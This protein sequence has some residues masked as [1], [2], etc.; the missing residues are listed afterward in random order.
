MKKVFFFLF[1]QRILIK[2]STLTYISKFQLFFQFYFSNKNSFTCSFSSS[3]FKTRIEIV[4]CSFPL[5]ILNPKI[6]NCQ[7]GKQRFLYYFFYSIFVKRERERGSIDI[8]LYIQQFSNHLNQQL[9]EINREK[10]RE[11]SNPCK[12]FLVIKTPENFLFFDVRF[13]SFC[14]SFFSMT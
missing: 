1:F 14:S 2:Y 3:N 4:F 7:H 8:L 6:I 11:R 13:V 5:L 9:R 12:S 10:E